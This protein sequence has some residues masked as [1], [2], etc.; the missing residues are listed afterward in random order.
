MI[1][2]NQ[3]VMCC[4]PKS[5]QLMYVKKHNISLKLLENA[6]QKA[7]NGLYS[8]SKCMGFLNESIVV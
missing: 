4:D 7:H 1:N 2:S 3:P 5:D 6:I 8:K